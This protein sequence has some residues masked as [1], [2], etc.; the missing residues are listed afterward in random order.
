MSKHKKNYLRLPTTSITPAIAD[1]IW[2]N[3]KEL[4]KRLYL[5][6]TKIPNFNQIVELLDGIQIITIMSSKQFPDTEFVNS[7]NP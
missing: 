4:D 3:G 5:I 7:D 2:P 1:L 6:D